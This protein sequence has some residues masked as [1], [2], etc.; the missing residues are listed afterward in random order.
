MGYYTAYELYIEDNPC[1]GYKIN[2]LEKTLVED[3]IDLM[4]VFEWG[5]ADDGY[6]G[7]CKWYNFKDDM[8]LLSARFPQILF[9]LR[10]HGE[11]QEDMW[12]AWY[13]NGGSQYC[14]AT[15]TYPPFDPLKLKRSI[16]EDISKIKYS[17]QNEVG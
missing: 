17:Y 6:S 13:L 7:Y 14:P 1:S 11:D 15:I 9:H 3:E 16:N 4:Q 5:N 2:D 8:E 12:E 10:G